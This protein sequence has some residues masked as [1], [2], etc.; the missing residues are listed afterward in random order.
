MQTTMSAVYVHQTWTNGGCILLATVVRMKRAFR[1]NMLICSFAERRRAMYSCTYIDALKL[2]WREIP[3]FVFKSLARIYIDTSVRTGTFA[4][5]STCV[6]MCTSWFSTETRVQSTEETDSTHTLYV[7][8]YWLTEAERTKTLIQARQERGDI[9]KFA[10]VHL[11]QPAWTYETYI[12][13]YIYRYLR[14]G[15]S[16]D[17]CILI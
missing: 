10:T 7:Y 17:R 16:V 13:I 5:I 6:W 4:E 11:Q 12:Y 1:I 2:A 9:E 14:I 8:R 3:N 15:R